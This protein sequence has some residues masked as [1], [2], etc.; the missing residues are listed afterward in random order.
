MVTI[1]K[2]FNKW[3]ICTLDG[4]YLW[5]CNKTPDNFRPAD[6]STYNTKID[7]NMK[8]LNVN[9]SQSFE[10]NVSMAVFNSTWN[11]LR[12]NFSYFT[13]CDHWKN[14]AE[15]LF[16]MFHSGIPLDNNF[17]LFAENWNYRFRFS[18]SFVD[19]IFTQFIW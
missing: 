15:Y 10:S 4:E 6:I 9:N 14:I 2:S 12:K 17:G 18:I 3:N 19:N 13:I 16:N 8:L 5:R 11:V 1:V 7:I